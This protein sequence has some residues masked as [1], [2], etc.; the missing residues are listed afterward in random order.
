MRGDH[1]RGVDV[2]DSL[3]LRYVLKIKCDYMDWIIWLSTEDNYEHMDCMNVR[4]FD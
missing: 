2:D 4:E 3:I 1:L